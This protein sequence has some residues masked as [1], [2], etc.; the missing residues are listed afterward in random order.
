MLPLVHGPVA[1][2]P[3][4]LESVVSGIVNILYHVYLVVESS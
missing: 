3:N 4:D 2:S 1:G